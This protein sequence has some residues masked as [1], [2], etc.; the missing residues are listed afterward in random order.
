[1]QKAFLKRTP[2]EERKKLIENHSKLLRFAY[3]REIPVITV[4]FSCYGKI[5]SELVPLLKKLK[6]FTIN[7]YQNNGFIKM[8]G[9]DPQIIDSD[10]PQ[11]QNRRL[12]GILKKKEIDQLILTGV[13]KRACVLNTAMGAKRRG[14]ELFTSEEL[15]NQRSEKEE[16]YYKNS[17]HFKTL[18]D[19]LEKLDK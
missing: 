2:V 19:L 8:Y 6:S 7:K 5:I 10:I 4:R 15:M 11:Y 18:S 13:Q 17:N 16:W 9:A 3:E 12:S 1:M 14:Y